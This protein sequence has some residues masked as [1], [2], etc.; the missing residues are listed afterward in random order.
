MYVLYI[1]YLSYYLR[2]DTVIPDYST[3][4]RPFR[5][6]DLLYLVLVSPERLE[7]NRTG[8]FCIN[9]GAPKNNEK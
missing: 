1:Y 6:R 8:S 9:E 3:T 7:D 4:K 5:I 2:A